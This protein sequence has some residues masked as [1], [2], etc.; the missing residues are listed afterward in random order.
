MLSIVS[1]AVEN[2]ARSLRPALLR[3]VSNALIRVTSDGLK[4]SRD[5]TVRPLFQGERLSDFFFLTIDIFILCEGLLSA[6]A[7]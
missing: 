6:Q 2:R 5:P 3:F 1:I 4:G 7:V